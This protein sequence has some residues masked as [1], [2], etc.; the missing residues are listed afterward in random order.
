MFALIFKYLE[1]TFA[2]ERFY[3]KCSYGLNSDCL[4]MVPFY[5]TDLLSF[6]EIHPF[7]EGQ[8]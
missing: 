1:L 4:K 3:L 5:W 2:R 6:S 7:E 8:H